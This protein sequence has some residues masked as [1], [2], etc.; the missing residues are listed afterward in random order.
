MSRDTRDAWSRFLQPMLNNSQALP[1][2]IR[3][4]VS[5]KIDFFFF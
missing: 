4:H 3:C 2:M 5:V 1:R